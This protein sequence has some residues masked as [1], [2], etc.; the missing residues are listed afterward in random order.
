MAV[1]HDTPQQSRSAK[2]EV[3]RQTVDFSNRIARFFAND[4]SKL[5]AMS[6]RFGQIT[7]YG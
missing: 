4:G 2:F 5:Q 1:I 3:L 6:A 7:A